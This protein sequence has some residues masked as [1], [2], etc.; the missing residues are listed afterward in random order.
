MKTVKLIVREDRETGELGIMVEGTPVINYPMVALEGML[1]AHDLLEHVNGVESIGSIGDE[2]EALGGVWYIRGQHYDI[3]RGTPSIYTPHE[4]LAADLINMG[5]MYIEG[6][7]SL[8]VPV[9]NNKAGDQEIDFQDIVALARKDLYSECEDYI[10]QYGM[11]N[12]LDKRNE[13]LDAALKLMRQGFRKARKKYDDVAAN[14]L[15][16]EIAEA[17]GKIINIIA[18]EGQEF[19]L[20]YDMSKCYANCWE[21][22]EEEMYA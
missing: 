14:S 6:G 16:W 2:L 17:M 1:V 11:S 20:Q 8:R 10:A 18:W 5:R 7:V 9:P 19:I 15:F 22:Y 3:R 4:S 13:Y 12:Y 21:H